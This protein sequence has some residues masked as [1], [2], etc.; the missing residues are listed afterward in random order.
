MRSCVTRPRHHGTGHGARPGP[1]CGPWSAK[2]A[3]HDPGSADSGAYSRGMAKYVLSVLGD[4]RAGL[5]DA[6]AGV[7]SGCGGNWEQSH[8]TEL[9]GKFA[10][11]VLV[12]VPDAA[13][14]RFLAELEPLEEHGLLDISVEEAGEG[15]APIA[16]VR[17]ELVGNDHPGIVHRVSHLL[18]QRNVSIDD[19]QTWT[20]IAP[21]AGHRLFHANA[22]LRLPDGVD[23][24]TLRA[25]LEELATDLMVD[26]DL[27]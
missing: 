4:D 1:F 19:L 22:V 2:M 11:V 9:A 18:S 20:S 14:E 13:V 23:R 12:T 24:V 26:I 15:A 10:G 7:V 3:V 6:L 25:D 8:M 5:V 21:M 27:D 16:Q 17:L